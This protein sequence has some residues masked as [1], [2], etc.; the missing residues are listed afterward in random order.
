MMPGLALPG[1]PGGLERALSTAI[2]RVGVSYFPPLAQ[3]PGLLNSLASTLPFQDTGNARSSKIK[4]LCD[5]RCREY[6]PLLL[7]FNIF[8]DTI[9]LT[10]GASS[11]SHTGNTAWLSFGIGFGNS[12][13]F[14]REEINMAC[15][16][17]HLS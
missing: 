17:N 1:I 7:L 10:A 3:V 4:F 14:N 9:N 6:L 15:H 16:C 8:V 13:V 5:L 12:V 11:G 2:L